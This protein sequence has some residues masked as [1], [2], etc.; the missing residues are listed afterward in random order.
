M[1]YLFMNTIVPL[2]SAIWPYLLAVLLFG[3]LIAIHELGHFL[4]AKLFDVK[5][6][7][8]A[9]G[10]GPTIFKRQKGETKYALRLFPIGGF[11]NMEGEDTDSDDD[12]AFFRKPC[13]QRFIIVAAGAVL[14]LILGVIVVAIVLSSDNLIGTRTINGFFEDS[15]S[16]NYGLMKDDE[17]LEIN[18]TK[19]YSYRGIGFNLVRDNDSSVDFKVKR[20]GQ[21]FDVNGVE[22]D[23]FEYEGRDYI[24][25][26]FQLIGVE[27]S[28]LSVTKAA[29]LDSASIV[30]LVRLSLTDMIS[31]KYG[32]KDISGPIGTISA[33]AD[34]TAQAKTF[35]D[36]MITALELLSYITINV[37]VFNLLPVP[38]LD[39]GRLFFIVIEAI[40]RKPLNRKYEGYIHATGLIALLL[41][42]AVITVSDIVKK[43]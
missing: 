18:G 16:N 14:N 32:L 31:G 9:L 22:F 10:M 39:G 6:N 30:Q 13:W 19:I 3:I 2:W 11:V 12:R 1:T 42:M 17:I 35:K 34:T 27:P 8:F 5:V 25:W 29:V 20:G 7:E 24:V 38:A 33:I 23:T 4:F 43:F 21:V 15:V 41:F 37:G 28:F 36:K 40:R 26:D